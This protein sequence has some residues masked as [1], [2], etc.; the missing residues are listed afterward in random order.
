MFGSDNDTNGIAPTFSST[1]AS[2]LLVVER[3]VVPMALLPSHFLWEEHP[4]NKR[5]STADQARSSPRAQSTS[6]SY[7]PSG[8]LGELHRQQRFASKIIRAW[9]LRR[10]EHLMRGRLLRVSALA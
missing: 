3:L 10:Q 8:A 7:Q 4:D 9:G 5:A 2:L 6:R 1:T